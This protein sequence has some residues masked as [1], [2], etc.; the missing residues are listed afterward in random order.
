MSLTDAQ[1][2]RYSRQI[3][4]PEIGGRGQA[5]LLAAHV[6]LAG[7]GEA[8]TAAAVLLGRAGVGAL[9]LLAH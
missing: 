6:V 5:R 7:A 1:I 2:E 8:A 4:L 3:L 9:D